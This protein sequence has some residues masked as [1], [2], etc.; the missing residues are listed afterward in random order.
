MLQKLGQIVPK[1]KVGDRVG[2]GYMYS[3]CWSMWILHKLWKEILC[4]S[5]V[6]NIIS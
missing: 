6:V 3:A 4:V 1:L 2:V 5:R